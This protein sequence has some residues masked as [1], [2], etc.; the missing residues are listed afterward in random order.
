MT[1]FS[2]KWNPQYVE[3]L[4]EHMQGPEGRSFISFSGAIGVSQ[5][6]LYVWY[7]EIPEFRAVKDKHQQ[8]RVKLYRTA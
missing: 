2:P 5:K 6:Q 3:K 1:K 7:R 4:R 8:P